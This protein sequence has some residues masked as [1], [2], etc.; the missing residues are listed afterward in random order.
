MVK[1]ELAALYEAEKR[2]IAAICDDKG[3]YLNPVFGEGP[4]TPL[5]MLI[6]EAP[7]KEE[8]KSS[9]PFVGKAGKQLDALL[10]K[11]K[12]DRAK[13]YV[14]NSVKYR[15]INKKERSVSNRTPS[16]AEV[17]AGLALLREEIRLLS[18]AVIVTLGNTPL[19]ALGMLGDK[20]LPAIGELHGKPTPISI[21]GKSI[22]LIP[23]YH[24][25][26]VIYNRALESVMEQDL[27]SLGCYIRKQEEGL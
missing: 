16:T 4:D 1:T 27:V 22:M 3:D 13:V 21:D 18:P 5:V 15:P 24:P 26:S 9:R 19:K 6:G 12:I 8:A 17:K 10:E 2:R 25:A 11:A 20:K 23:Q 14:T 7:G